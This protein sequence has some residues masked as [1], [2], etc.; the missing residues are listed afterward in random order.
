[1][2]L[3]RGQTS[4]LGVAVL[5]GGRGWHLL[6]LCFPQPESQRGASCNR[7]PV[8]RVRVS[9]G[10]WLALRG[11]LGDVERRGPAPQTEQ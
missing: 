7:A 11:A 1:M 6:A 9:T 2:A 5:R 3:V 4:N 10:R 8:H